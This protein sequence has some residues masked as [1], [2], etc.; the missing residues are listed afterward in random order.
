MKL[1]DEPEEVIEKPAAPSESTHDGVS[2]P[3]S[4]PKPVTPSP[5]APTDEISHEPFEPSEAKVSPPS[6]LPTVEDATDDTPLTTPAHVPPSPD[7]PGASIPSP[8]SGSA[9][10]CP[11]E[12]NSEIGSDHEEKDEDS[13]SEDERDPDAGFVEHPSGDTGGVDTIDLTKSEDIVFGSEFEKLDAYESYL[14]Q[15]NPW[16]P[17]LRRP[18]FP[19]QIIGFRWMN[20]RHPLGGGLIADKVGCGK[21]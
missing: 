14:D 16:H 17:G 10:T 18:L 13:Q 9:A 5:P 20:D 8:P 15:P 6:T 21:V 7:R 3:E 4:V 11:I 19:A 2:P 12:L 1:D